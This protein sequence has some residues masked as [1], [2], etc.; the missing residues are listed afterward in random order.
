MA[1]APVSSGWKSGPR[2]SIV[3]E[4]PPMASTEK[5]MAR[6]AEGGGRVLVGR[7]SGG[8][9]KRWKRNCPATGA[10]SAR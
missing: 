9:G 10:A 5:V 8:Y 2:V 1:C 4:G 6:R 3:A 7:A